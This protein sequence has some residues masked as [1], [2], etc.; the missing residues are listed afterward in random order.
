MRRGLFTCLTGAVLA[1]MGAVPAAAG[2]TVYEEGDKKLEI[3]GR[4]QIQYLNFETDGD[5]DGDVEFDEIFFRRLRLYI[6]GTVTRDWYAKIQFDFGKA[7]DNNE[8]AV[9]DAYIQYLGLARHKITIGNSKTPFSREYLTSSKRQQLI[10]RSFG[11]DHDFGSPDRNMGVRL[12]GQ[13]FDKKLG[14]M[15]SAGAEDHDPAV[16]RMDFDTPVNRDSDYNQGWLAAARVDW[17]PLGYVALDQGD[18]HSDSWRFNLSLA[19]YTWMNDDDNNTY[20]DANGVT[21]VEGKVEGKVDLDSAHGVELSA[22]VRGHGFSADVEYQKI[23]GDIVDDTFTGGL[24][25]NGTTDLDIFA[26]EAGYMLPNNHLELVAGW[27]SLDADN[28]DDAW[29]RIKAGVNWFW[30]K[31]KAKTQISYRKSD[32]YLG[33][34]GVDADAITVQMQ[35]V[36]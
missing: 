23:T 10:E 17:H 9:K 11:G 16:N 18:F 31:H 1:L 13:Q 35:F 20:T 34:A 4:I 36:F 32:N 21:T 6:A 15:V 2:I 8:V 25:R 30:N 28:Y 29:T 27:D 33:Q 7:E 12:E 22:G 3:G 19:A 14:Y 5:P 24:Y 26:V